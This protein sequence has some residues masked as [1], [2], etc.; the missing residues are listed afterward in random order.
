MRFFKPPP[1][2]RYVYKPRFWD[3]DKEGL[4]ER[5]DWASGEKKEDAEILKSRIADHFARR[6]SRG[7][8]DSGYRAREVSRSNF[9]LVLVLAVIILLTYLVLMALPGYLVM[10][11]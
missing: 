5:L 7:S 1:H 9:R 10:F 4:R 8:V 11:E 6:S 2:Q 3:P